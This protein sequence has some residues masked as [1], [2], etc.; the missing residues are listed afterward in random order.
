MWFRFSV[1]LAVL[2]SALALSACFGHSFTRFASVLEVILESILSS[3]TNHVFGAASEASFGSFWNHFGGKFEDKNHQK[4][5][6][7]VQIKV[8]DPSL[9]KPFEDRIWKDSGAYFDSPNAPK[10]SLGQL[11]GPRGGLLGAS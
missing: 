10:S 1:S 6:T 3:F 7:V 5:W 4:P 11:L 2:V 9:P 8:F